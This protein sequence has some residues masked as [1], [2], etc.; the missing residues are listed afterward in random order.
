MQSTPTNTMPDSVQ[1]KYYIVYKNTRQKST[2]KE[3]LIFPTVKLEDY[4]LVWNFQIDE[5]SL[6]QI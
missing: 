6:L 3:T 1:F 2:L 4:Q 5:I